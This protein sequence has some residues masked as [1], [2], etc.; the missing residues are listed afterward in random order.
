MTDCD[1]CALFRMP[2]L[3]AEFHYHFYLLA[4]PP[5][6][7]ILRSRLFYNSTILQGSIE[8]DTLRCFLSECVLTRTSS[9]PHL[10][11]WTPYPTALNSFIMHTY[12]S[13]YRHVCRYI[14]VIFQGFKYTNL[15]IDIPMDLHRIQMWPIHYIKIF[16]KLEERKI[17][18]S[19]RILDRAVCL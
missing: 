12:L 9:S 11:P 18:M 15:P 2:R 16:Q 10:I 19:F 17:F 3:N 8:P 14:A 13:V 6:G 4:L 7:Q 5:R 1:N